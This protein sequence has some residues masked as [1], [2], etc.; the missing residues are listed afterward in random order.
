M[1]NQT[2]LTPAHALTEEELRRNFEIYRQLMEKL[3]RQYDIPG[4]PV[5]TPMGEP[6]ESPYVV[7]PVF[8]Y[9]AHAST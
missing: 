7:E 4:F 5:I 1:D 6:A 3:A 8:F 9:R 2:S